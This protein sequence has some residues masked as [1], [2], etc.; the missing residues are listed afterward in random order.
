MKLRPIIVLCLLSIAMFMINSGFPAEREMLTKQEE[1]EAQQTAQRFVKRIQQTRDVVPLLDEMFLPDFIS[2]FVS[3]EESVSPSIYSRLTPAERLRLFVAQ[4]NAAYMGT[5][6]AI[7]TPDANRSEEERYRAAFE[8]FLPSSTAEK[9]RST[10]WRNNEFQFSSY[11][12]FQLR[13]PQ[14]EKVLSEARTHL[15]N[16]GLEQRPEFQRKLDD[17]VRGTGINYRVRTYIGGNN[18]QDCET[19][20]GFPPSQRFFRVETPLL[21]GVVMTKVGNAMRIVRVTAVDGD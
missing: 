21:L 14:I 9:L 16:Q 18:I 4:T 15:V 17:T 1:R 8:S 19:I 12:D 20:V 10:V 13:L 11:E 6:D 3:G 7:C 5:L 2:H